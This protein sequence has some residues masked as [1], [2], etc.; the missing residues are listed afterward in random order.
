[1]EAFAW[2]SSPKMP[3]LFGN[4]AKDS[5]YIFHPGKMGDLI[6]AL[7]VMKA[8]SHK[9][10]PVHLITSGLCHQLVPI[11][12]EQTYFASVQIDDEHPYAIRECNCEPWFEFP[13]GINGINLSHR[14]KWLNEDGCWTELVAKVAGIK[15]CP[16]DKD[17]LPSLFAHR[18][19]HYCYEIIREGGNHPMLRP[20]TAILAPEAETMPMVD[21]AVWQQIAEALKQWFT[22]I[23]VGLKPDSSFPGCTDLRGLTTVPTLAR[24][25]AEA[26]IV[27]TALSLPFHLARHAKTPTFLLSDLYEKHSFPIDTVWVAYTSKQVRDVIETARRHIGE[28]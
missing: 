12:W 11:L 3:K 21:T 7:P 15:L 17:V 20:N 27:I 5:F 8:L 9:H 26:R 6:Y 1:M 16:E 18:V 23:I 22:V 14:P 2:A 10:G 4:A 24:I 25:L 19:W 13:K 28:T